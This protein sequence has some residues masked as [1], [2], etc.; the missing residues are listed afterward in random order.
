MLNKKKV[1]TEKKKL[2]SITAKEA[3][4]NLLK[5]NFFLNS[6]VKKSDEFIV[7]GI[8]TGH[9]VNSIVAGD[10]VMNKPNAQV[11][12][13]QNVPMVYLDGT[14]VPY[15]YASPGNDIKLLEIFE[16][17]LLVLVP[18][19][20][21]P[22]GDGQWSIGYMETAVLGD[23][24]EVNYNTIVWNDASN[25]TVV[26][27]NGN[28]IYSLPATQTVQFL[29]ET[30]NSNYFCILFNGINGELLTGYVEYSDGLFYRY[31][32][33]RTGALQPP[34]IANN[35]S[36]LP[37]GINMDLQT[38]L[39][40]LDGNTTVITSFNNINSGEKVPTYFELSNGFGSTVLTPNADLKTGTYLN[41]L[42]E[43]IDS[44]SATNLCLGYYHHLY[45]PYN[46]PDSISCKAQGIT[47]GNSLTSNYIPGT[48]YVLGLKIDEASFNNS[49][50]IYMSEIERCASDFM[51][52]LESVIQGNYEVMLYTSLNMINNISTPPL[53]ESNLTDS[54]L[55]MDSYLPNI[56]DSTYEPT[57][58]E[59][60]NAFYEMN[61]ITWGG[62]TGW[63][64]W[65]YENSNDIT[66]CIVNLD[67]IYV[68]NMYYNPVT[69]SPNSGS[70]GSSQP[71][72][73]LQQGDIVQINQSAEY[74]AI[75]PVIGSMIND[76]FEITELININTGASDQSGYV[77]TDCLTQQ[78]YNVYSYQV[79]KQ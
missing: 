52:G 70:T 18:V 10:T 49:T 76:T 59:I 77:V 64:V 74:F 69:S 9:A 58:S 27:S 30:P 5:T 42:N 44:T 41:T 57:N 62:Q 26:D 11:V 40:T 3:F 6:C 29:Y 21:G 67:A 56:S 19:G 45:D 13:N 17:M 22:E 68:P 31:S 34:G 48:C 47:F 73:T 12:G 24:V 4:E 43:I 38:G 66:S 51:E 32:S 53:Y 63:S 23:T 35:N 14:A 72:N 60:V 75:G 15:G 7:T 8:P 46:I 1:V 79:T 39:S 78:E 16:G 36:S 37:S 25:K 20:N 50:S 61:S 28:F 65:G 54:L 2:I 55:W 33:L 71:T